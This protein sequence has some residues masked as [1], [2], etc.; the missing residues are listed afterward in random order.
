LCNNLLS[1]LFV[2]C[3]TG[4]AVFVVLPLGLLRNVDS[5]SS[6]CT[7]TIGFYLCLVLKVSITHAYV[8]SLFS[9]QHCIKYTGYVSMNDRIIMNSYRLYLNIVGATERAIA[10]I[11]CRQFGTDH[12]KFHCQ[13]PSGE[14]SVIGRR[15]WIQRALSRKAS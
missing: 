6:V 12:H 1:E 13:L 10:G 14:P 15:I 7:A 11:S 9:E 4:L 5:L 3:F 2:C 8:F